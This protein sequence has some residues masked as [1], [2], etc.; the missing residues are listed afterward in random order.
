MDGVITIFIIGDL[1]TGKC[2]TAWK[3]L[4]ENNYAAAVLDEATTVQKFTSYVIKD[5]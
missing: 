5:S 1:A 4:I 2:M 3:K